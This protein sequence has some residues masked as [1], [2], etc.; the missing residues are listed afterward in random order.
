[1]IDRFT[2]ITGA[3]TGI[4]R[5]IAERCA[6]QGM[7]LVLVALPGENLEEI[8]YAV[9][10][11]HRIKAHFL[12]IDL[13]APQAT[14]YV[15]AWCK[16]QQ[17]QVNVLINNAGIGYE[18]NFSDFDSS[19]YE[20]LLSLN[21]VALT[22]LTREFLPDLK[23]QRDA[24]ILNVAS[25]GGYY[26]MPFKAV[27]AAS[28]SYVI[29][30][31]EA[32]HEE[33]KHTSVNVSLLCPAGVDSFQDSSTRIDQIGWIAK[34]GRLNPRDVATAAVEGILKRKRRIIPGAVNIFFYYLSK[35]LPTRV[36]AWLVH[37]VLT[38]FHSKAKAVT[39]KTADKESSI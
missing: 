29:S 24:A 23:R 28:K 19:F 39:S 30:F 21:I 26:P 27:Y 12:E 18:G 22:L 5:A 32:L 25:F 35:P 20:N 34:F 11:E 15:Y 7:N 16:E 3:S 14:K 4:G 13:T 10:G 9:A 36:K 2:L 33:L 17:L 38:K 6:E 31:S 37:F 1:M 8:S